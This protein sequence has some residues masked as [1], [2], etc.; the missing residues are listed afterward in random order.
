VRKTR[1]EPWTEQ[2][3][4][5]FEREKEQLQRIFPS[6]DIHHIGSTSV[7]NIGYAK[8]I[9]DIL[10]VVDDIKT[11]EARYDEMKK[12]GY[13]PRGENGIVGRRYF[14]KGQEERTHHVHVYEVGNMHSKKHLLF[15]DYLQ[16]HADDARKYG[17]LKVQLQRKF[18]ENTH[19]YQ[20]GKEAFVNNLM[21]K[22]EAW[23]RSYKC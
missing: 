16:G 12:L 15:K 17:E 6:A 11:V 13:T 20:N 7:R 8:P 18:P 19:D 3:G 4:M 23:D 9:I 21:E 14:I 5:T 1:I 2:W 22:A 10:I